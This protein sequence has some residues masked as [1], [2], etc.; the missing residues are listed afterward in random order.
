MAPEVYDASPRLQEIASECRELMPV[1]ITDVADVLDPKRPFRILLGDG[2]EQIV[3]GET[4][5]SLRDGIEIETRRIPWPE[6]LARRVALRWRAFRL[7]EIGS[8]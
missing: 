6:R 2:V 5:T 1:R 4:V 8:K 7:R 3:T